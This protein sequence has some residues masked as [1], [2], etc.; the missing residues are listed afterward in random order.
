MTPVMVPVMAPVRGP[1]MAPDP[2][3]RIG[4][5]EIPQVDTRINL[6]LR[7][8]PTVHEVEVALVAVRNPL[9]ALGIADQHP[10]WR[11]PGEARC[12]GWPH[13]TVERVRVTGP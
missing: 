12:G 13:R 4:S 5:Q 3:G 8:S 6:Y 7:S 2:A 1:V 9:P 10:R 11:G